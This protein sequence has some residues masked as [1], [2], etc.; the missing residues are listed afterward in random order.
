MT[1]GATPVDRGRGSLL[2][3]PGPASYSPLAH[4]DGS[5]DVRVAVGIITYHR[6][7]GLRRLIGQLDNLVFE[8][9]A[10]DLEIVIVDNDPDGSARDFC[11]EVEPHLRWP[12]Q[13]YVEPRRGIPYARNR[14][15]S[16]A[17]EDR[18]FVA[19]IDDDEV[20]EP[21]WM[22]D[23]LRVQRVYNADVV[24][25]PVLPLFGE[26]APAWVA[27]GGFFQHTFVRAGYRT[28]HSLELADTNNV[29]ISTRVLRGMDR[30]FD[31]RF[32][33]TGGSDTH[34]FMR[35]FQA[36]YKLVWADSARV[37]EHIPNSRANARWIL[38]RAYRLGNTRSL[39]ELDLEPSIVGQVAPAVKGWGR[40]VQGLVYL[41]PALLRGRH[42][43]VRTLCNVCYGAGR[44]AGLIGL[45]YKEYRRFFGE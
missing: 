12:L 34:F 40:I 22:D 19:F 23:L 24:Y 43:L 35:V 16:C 6:P 13:Y 4:P 9:T 20:P 37:Y 39:C 17:S 18:D 38:Q 29:L 45:R 1:D 2:Q 11:R 30:L 36:G 27:K 26:G 5:S 8:G 10:P 41:P 3:R 21:S 7:E 31:G 25:G 15:I 42:E 44:L 33:L 28:G 32:A 14:V